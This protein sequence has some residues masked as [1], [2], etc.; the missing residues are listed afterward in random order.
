MRSHDG[1]EGDDGCSCGVGDRSQAQAGGMG[2][3]SARG[4]TRTVTVAASRGE[5]NAEENWE[6]IALRSGVIPRNYYNPGLFGKKQNAARDRD[7]HPVVVRTP[8]AITT[9]SG[10]GAILISSGTPR[11]AQVA[12]TFSPPSGRH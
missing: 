8:R 7:H 3:C 1:V 2:H 4:G 5:A 6:G 12:P 11:A 9:I 10:E